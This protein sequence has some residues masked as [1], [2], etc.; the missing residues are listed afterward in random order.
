M[1]RE[2]ASSAPEAGA[3]ASA[4]RPVTVSALAAD[5]LLQMM[6]E[7]G[8]EGS[9][10]R[11][12]VQGGGCSGLQYGMGFAAEPEPDDHVFDDGGLRVFVDPVSIQYMQGAR[13]DFVD[14]LMG[15]GFKVENP[16]AVANCGCGQSFS[17]SG[18]APADGA[19]GSG[20]GCQ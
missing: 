5:K 8:L 19:C 11:V 20:C 2:D 7:K 14:S 17:T 13:V 15:G 10:L 18:G 1:L 12:F 4:V 3:D 16:N 9:G 6:T